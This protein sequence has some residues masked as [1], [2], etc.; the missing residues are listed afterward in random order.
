M[1]QNWFWDW[2]C[3]CWGFDWF[4]ISSPMGKGGFVGVGSD[5]CSFLFLF[6]RFCMYVLHNHARMFGDV[7]PEGRK[8]ECTERSLAFVVR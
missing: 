5:F 3:L 6:S 1:S 4:L 7:V 2:D 8:L